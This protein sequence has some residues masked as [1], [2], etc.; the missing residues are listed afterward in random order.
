LSLGYGV[1]AYFDT[2]V[3]FIRLYGVMSLLNLCVI[4]LYFSFDGLRSL[5]GAPLTSKISLGNMGFS[6]PTCATVNF[7]VQRNLV[8]CSYGTI[9]KVYSFGIHD[10]DKN[11]NFTFEDLNDNAF[12]I[13]K[14]KNKG[15]RC[16]NY[17]Y[18][19]CNRYLD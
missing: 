5:A 11:G 18:D 13:F 3:N 14:P 19:I 6:E 12:N 8:Q 7:G 16:M 4:A 17:E 15:V 2:L 1:N 9:Q 10:N